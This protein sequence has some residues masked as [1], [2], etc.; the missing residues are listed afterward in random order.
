MRRWGWLI[1]VLFATA[2]GCKPEPPPVQE[3]KRIEEPAKDAE[4]KVPVKPLDS[5]PAA[6]Q[7]LREVLDSHTGKDPSKLKA[8]QACSFTRKGI[9]EAAATRTPSTWQM[10]LQVP[11]NFRLRFELELGPGTKQKGQFLKNPGGGWVTAGE[12]KAESRPM[13]AEDLRDLTV[14]FHEIGLLLLFPLA[15]AKTVCQRAADE[16]DWLG[17]HVWTPQLEYALLGI[18]KKTK[19]ISR[20]V[21]SGREYRMSIAKEILIREYREFNGVKLGSKLYIKAGGRGIAEWTSLEVE[22]GKSLDPK[23]FEKP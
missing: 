17:L 1:P 3:A 13:D 20:I 12:A 7:L 11:D 23:I 8:F 22:T 6:V 10:D 21:Y 5:E 19:L 18:D 2:L 9:I 4:F 14:H 16:G 15:D